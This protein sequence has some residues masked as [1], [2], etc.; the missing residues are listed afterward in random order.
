[1]TGIFLV[2]HG[3]TALNAERCLRGRI[4][5]P[6]DEV[7]LREAESLGELFET[8]S[9]A[10]VI[11]S[12]LARA[13]RTAEAIADRHALTVEEDFGLIDRDWG[14]WAG[15]SESEVASRFGGLDDVEGAEAVDSLYERVTEAAGRAVGRAAGSPVVL[16]AHDAVNRAVIARLVPELGVASRIPQRTG[17]WNL[18][19]VS[20]GRWSA[21][22]IDA[23]PGDGTTPSVA[24]GSA[25][26]HF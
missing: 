11:T 25:I 21:P 14:P 7:G 4:D 1:M 19:C 9:L 15:R 17:C 24:L 6:L 8:I 3:R 13:R 12:P 26:P 18:L 22:V 2:R 5:V 20:G 10:A 16:V 23:V